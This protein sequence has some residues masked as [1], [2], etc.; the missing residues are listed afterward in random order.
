MAMLAK[1]SAAQGF[2]SGERVTVTFEA[3]VISDGVR[4]IARL[5]NGGQVDIPWNAVIRKRAK[6][7]LDGI[8]DEQL[9][10]LTECEWWTT[11]ES[12]EGWI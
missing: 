3:L 7:M 6:R 11:D 8:T 4:L 5:P 9:R 2:R 1:D 12:D 10:H